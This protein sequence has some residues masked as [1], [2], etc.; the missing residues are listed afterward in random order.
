V[1]SPSPSTSR[2]AASSFKGWRKIGRR[3]GWGIGDQAFSS[4]TNF[5]LGIMVARTQSAR[6]F[7]A[8][9]LAFAT[10]V[11]ALN[12]SRALSTEPLVV[13][14]SAV[15]PDEWRRG[16]RS[17]TGSAVGAGIV[18][19]LV[20]L[21]LS[22]FMGGGLGSAF[23]ALG[24]TL[25][26]LLLQDS[27]R[28]A[29]FAQG[30]G[31]QAF[32]NDAM[33]AIVLFPGL[34]LLI[35]TGHAT[36]FWLTFCWGGA[37]TAAGLFG[38]RQ[39]RVV[40][41]PQDSVRWLREQWDLAPR[42]LGEFMAL[43]GTTQVS[44]YFIGAIASLE[45]VGAL[46][47]GQIL[48]GPVYA[49]SIGVRMVATP[50]VVR[51]FKRSPRRLREASAALSASLAGATLLWGALLFLLPT[52]AGVALLGSSWGPAHRV[53]FPMTL[54]MASGGA[55]GGMTAGL[56]ALAA[57]RRSLRARLFTSVTRIAGGVVGAMLGGTVAAA[58]GLAISG[59]VGALVYWD[60][61]VRGLRDHT[62]RTGGDTDL[63]S[64]PKTA[65]I[66]PN[67]IHDLS[68]GRGGAS[69]TTPIA[70]APPQG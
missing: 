32:L 56:R 36:V 18:A 66:G 9:S 47:A 61:L 6:E 39:A 14:Y 40:P 35:S 16:V 68:L 3:A 50:E 58:W 23:L 48:L 57:A 41:R 54:L 29:F 52:R 51:L 7:G 34:A 11:V 1:D 43:S 27:W 31:R 21:A 17:A 67:L 25:P 45:S 60:Q 38:L 13:R 42:F 22:S 26:G 37:A 49:F 70:E 62:V 19:G 64:P 65:S 63:T 8:F 20:C 30:R 44:F 46:R 2:S 33:W 5:A 12:V 15:E 69:V 4:L 10:Y 55:I 24:L 53:L 28:F 59:C